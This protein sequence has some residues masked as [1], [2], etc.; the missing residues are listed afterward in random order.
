MIAT[1]CGYQLRFRD[2]NVLKQSK[3]K[4]VVTKLFTSLT[5]VYV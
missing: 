5:N 2:T 1:I 4:K 3:R